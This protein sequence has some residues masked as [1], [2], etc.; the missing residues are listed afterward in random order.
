L[1]DKCCDQ[2]WQL[3]GG[4]KY[5]TKNRIREYDGAQYIQKSN[6]NS[7]I[8][9]LNNTVPFEEAT[10]SLTRSQRF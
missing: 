3:I 9:L 2:A 5:P 8:L 7:H 1:G 10:I 4:R 6:D